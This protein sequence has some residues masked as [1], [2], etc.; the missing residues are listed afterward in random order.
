MPPTSRSLPCAGPKIYWRAD[1][2]KSPG[3]GR[4]LVE[5]GKICG[6]IFAGRSSRNQLWNIGGQRSGLNLNQLALH[7]ADIGCKI[8]DGQRVRAVLRPPRSPSSN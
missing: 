7:A 2:V 8:D 6:K 3:P 1:L 4:D 5:D